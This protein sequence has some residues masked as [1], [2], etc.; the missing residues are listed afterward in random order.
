[1]MEKHLVTG[2]L[3]HVDAGKTTLSESMLYISGAIR[4]QGR[5]D[6]GDSFLD[7]NHMEQERG[8]TIFAG[9]AQLT[10]GDMCL[11][12]LDTP[13][14]VDFSPEMER[15]L[16][17]LDAAVLVIS[18]PDGVTGQVK[19][20]WKLLNYYEIPVFLFV[21][22]MDQDGMDPAL[23]MQE[24][25]R[26]LG[27]ACVRF[28]GP[29]ITPEN[30]EDIAVCDDGLLERV[31][32][33]K[34]VTDEDVCRLV[35][36]RRMFPVCFG[37][38]LHN[39]GVRE[40]LEVIGRY[41]ADP[42]WPEELSAR[43]FRITHDDKGNRLTWMKIT[44]GTLHV[45]DVLPGVSELRKADQIRV[46][47]GRTFTAVQQAEA[48]TVCAVLGLS[49]THAGEIIGNGGDENGEP[50]ILQPVFTKSILMEPDED[51]SR[52]L[53]CLQMLEEEDPMLHVRSDPKTGDL[54]VQIMGDVQTE[55]LQREAEERYGIRIGFGPASLVYKETIAAPTEGV[56]HYE[57]LRHYAEVHLLL[58]PAS[59]GTG[60]TFSSVLS[61][62]VL[63]LNWQKMIL[64]VLESSEL[65]GVLTGAGVTDLHVTL[66]GG[67][68]SEKHTE[69]G[70]FRQATLRAFRQG[71][72]MAES[73]L[74]EP[75]YDLTAVIPSE[76]SGRFLTDIRRMDGTAEVTASDGKTDEI[77][78]RIPAAS[79]GDYAADVRAYTH[80][81]GSVSVS[82]GG[83]EPCR[84]P[85]DIIL[86]SG[87]DP[88]ADLENTPDS[89]FCSHGAGMVI[90][91]DHVR[92][93]MHVDTGFRFPSANS[94]QEEKTS[95]AETVS[96]GYGDQT[97]GLTPGEIQSRKKS[98][99][100]DDW[101]AE[102]RRRAAGEE[103]LKRIFEQTYGEGSWTTP[104]HNEQNE[105]NALAGIRSG[106]EKKPH[107][108]GRKK[109]GKDDYL[110]VDGYNIIFAWEEL[111]E[112]ASRN[113]D[114]ARDRLIE[115]LEGFQGTRSGY[116]ILV[117]DA[118]KVRGGQREVYHR[119]NM[120]IVYT[121]EAETADT[122]IMKTAHN[123]KD[124]G[125]VTVATS[126]G[127]IQMIIFGAGARRMS[128]RELEDEVIQSAEDLRSRYNLE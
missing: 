75:C 20:L 69:G 87:Y 116:L 93:Y 127:I 94:D 4:K 29:Q 36:G 35:A 125:N 123:L 48:G 15:T 111:R 66:I 88:E 91:W 3:A 56:G 90:P 102:E 79:L 34:P 68:A 52:V 105:R 80:G 41:S 9:Q 73:I 107:I 6:H 76:N 14:H 72:M 57:P 81:A 64:S 113:L 44:G 122:Y 108:P 114:A 101:H 54:T 23:I 121:K 31:L 38:A 70:D 10:Y 32:G 85:E 33:G 40:L 83:Y 24:L 104:L 117:F 96:D 19:T 82:P 61:T 11:T 86:A 8:I 89:V 17:V 30:E 65:C 112:L 55:I 74:L 58:E 7:T 128:A 98:A 77:S 47:A 71:L 26:E 46:Y 119:A 100:S 45:K 63:S 22:K 92:E 2:I 115:V 95:S 84:N 62:D 25:K 5:V 13:G 67:R 37:S 49:G 1:M 120:D 53:H 106:S 42:Q 27:S 12:L 103:E 60:L 118:Y 126:D 124:K 39:E 110:L 50:P 97:R 59:R 16:M 43:V 28:Q 99:G 109:T 21:N 78:G 18:A 51:R